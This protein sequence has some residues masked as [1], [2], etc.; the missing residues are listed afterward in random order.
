[1]SLNTVT[2]LNHCWRGIYLHSCCPP[3]YYIIIS[4]SFQAV[5]TALLNPNF[6]WLPNLSASQ[7]S[8][9]QSFI[10][11]CHGPCTIHPGKQSALRER[12]TPLLPLQRGSD[13]R[14]VNKQF[15]TKCVSHSGEEGRGS[16]WRQVQFGLPEKIAEC[17][18]SEKIQ[19]EESL[20][21]ITGHN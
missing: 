6:K 12:Q 16:P 18:Y 21:F 2:S 15:C 17:I 4:F 5:S 11:P 8:V 7:S 13:R 9:L 14:Q 19:A 20:H 10:S 3:L 1:M